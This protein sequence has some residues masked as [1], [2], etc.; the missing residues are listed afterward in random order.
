[1]APRRRAREQR[2]DPLG[3]AD[4][5]NGLVPEIGCIAEAARDE[6]RVEDERDQRARRELALENQPAP[7]P[8]RQHRRALTGEKRDAARRRGR[9]D[10]AL[11]NRQRRLQGAAIAGR[12]GRFAGESA[13][14]ADA[15]KPLFGDGPSLRVRVLH[16]ARQ[17]FH[18]PTEHR[19]GDDNGRHRQDHD[20]RQQRRRVEEQRRSADAPQDVP[21]GIRQV[22]AERPLERRDGGCES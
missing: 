22:V 2:E 7:G 3:R 11:R 17:P 4:R 16:G 12:F 14:R 19:R 21:H 1:M 18:A 9:G 10:L 20:D 8:D 13:Q 15:G 6:K 5:S